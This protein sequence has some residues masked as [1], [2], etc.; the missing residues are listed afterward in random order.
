MTHARTIEERA[1]RPRPSRLLLAAMVLA[2]GVEAPAGHARAAAPENDPSIPPPATAPDIAFTDLKAAP[3]RLSEFRG[4]VVLLEF[5][6]PWCAPCREGFS[7]LDALQARHRDNFSVLAVTMEE[8]GRSIDEFV[9]AHPSRFVVGRD[10]EGRS[11]EAFEVRV[12]PTS[13]LIDAEGRVAAR[14]EGGTAAVHEAIARDVELL[15]NGASP[16]GVS[17]PAI[18]TQSKRGVIRPW[19]RG[20]L[21]DPIMSLDGDVVTRGIEEEIHASKEAAAGTGG[22]AGGGCGCN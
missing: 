21:A 17:G 14:H 10:P 11:G 4:R 15:L 16:A 1:A 6:A 13:I 3:H 19:Q 7:F 22:V 18:A 20:Y 5:W 2:A 8:D 9:A 12:L